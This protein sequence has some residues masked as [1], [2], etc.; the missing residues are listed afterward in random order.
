MVGYGVNPPQYV[1]HRSASC[2]AVGPCDW[3]QLN[4]AN[5][6]P[7]ILIGGLVGGP[8]SSDAFNDTRRNDVGNQAGI[9]NNAVFQSV[10]AGIK[11]Q[12]C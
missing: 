1:H 5:P 12:T 10:L 7:N 3:D 11:S 8:S 9:D 6:N 4:S 2:Q